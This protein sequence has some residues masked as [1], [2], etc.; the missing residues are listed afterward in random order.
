MRKLGYTSY[1]VQ[2]GIKMQPAKLECRMDQMALMYK[3]IFWTDA[4]H[5]TDISSK[6]C[7]KPS[8][9]VHGAIPKNVERS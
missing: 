3:D 9:H 7:R 2:T 5:T 1:V 8:D 4:V 6:L